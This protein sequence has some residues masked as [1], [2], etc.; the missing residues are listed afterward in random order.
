MSKLLL[1]SCL[2]FLLAVSLTGQTSNWKKYDN[3]DGNFTVWFPGEP[4]DSPNG[5]QNSVKSHTLMARDGRAIFTVIYTVHSGPQAV[6]DAT[7]Q[8]FKNAV[9]KELP[10]CATEVEKAPSLAI[11][12]YI[13]HWYRL[14]CDMPGKVFIEGNLYWGKNYA[15]AVMAMYPGSV[16]RPQMEQQFLDSFSVP[17]AA[18]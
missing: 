16:E 18:N 9:F 10:K 1:R 8:V 7:Y 4:Q 3:K 17:A 15:Y 2:L 14:N 11:D 12:S 13:G 6:D 5:D